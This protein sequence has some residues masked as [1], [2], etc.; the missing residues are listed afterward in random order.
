M[1]SAGK[2]ASE[3]FQRL[4]TNC[5]MGWAVPVC[6]KLCILE[7]TINSG[8]LSAIDPAMSDWA[9]GVNC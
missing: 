4:S 6:T 3:A 1:K 7:P 2:L 5:R 9:C 8:A